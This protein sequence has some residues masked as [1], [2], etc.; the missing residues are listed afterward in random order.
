VILH[1]RLKRLVRAAY[2]CF[3]DSEQD[4]DKLIEKTE[5]ET[6]TEKP[7]AEET[8]EDPGQAFSFAKIWTAE[9]DTLEELE[10][11]GNLEATD[12]W[13]QALKLIAMEQT[14]TKATERTGRGV[15]R[16][17]AMA[18]ESQVQLV[19]F[20]APNSSLSSIQQKLGFLDSPIKDKPR[21]RK[22]KK[23]RS[24]VSASEASDYVN[25][26]LSHSEISGDESQG[27]VEQDIAE[28]GVRAVEGSELPARS[29]PL[30]AVCA[31][32]GNLHQGTCD[33]VERSENLVHYRQVLFTEQT[34]ESSEERVCSLSTSLLCSM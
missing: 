29:P 24:T 1:V 10:D 31:M 20:P 16:K 4:L 2:S 27:D 15:R 9:N 3:S 30:I 18:A 32:C 19:V 33:M 17:A 22:R 25:A 23:S 8:G 11:Q 26:D 28:L 12:S 14:Q 21:G 13:A 34:G 7:S 6:E 5:T